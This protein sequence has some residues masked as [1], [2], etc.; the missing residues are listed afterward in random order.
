MVAWPV[1][2]SI[3]KVSSLVPL[4]IVLHSPREEE[5][6]RSS[7]VYRYQ[8]HGRSV[9]GDRVGSPGTARV[10]PASST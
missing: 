10:T 4:S 7:T 6:L 8:R 1:R 5:L 9:R 2:S 3:A